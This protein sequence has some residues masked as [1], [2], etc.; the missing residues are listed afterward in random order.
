MSAGALVTLVSFGYEQLL[1][2]SHVNNI[3]KSYISLNTI[4]SDNDYKVTIPRNG[5]S[6][7]LKGLI[8]NRETTDT[9][10]NIEYIEII[11]GTTSIIN[12]PYTLFK[13]IFP[14]EETE[15]T[16]YFKCDFSMFLPEEIYL[17]RL[18]FHQV[19]VKIH[20][21]NHTNIKNIVLP[22]E[23]IF[24]D[25]PNRHELAIAEYKQNCIQTIQTITYNLTTSQP[26]Q[27]APIVTS[28]QTNI[29]V[30]S[31]SLLSKGLFIECP[32]N[33]IKSI[34]IILQSK[35][36]NDDMN[37]YQYCNYDKD[38]INIVTK[39]I[40]PDLLYLP[41]NIEKDYAANNFA[42]Y[43][44]GINMCSFNN[45][46]IHIN[47]YKRPEKLRIHSLTFNIFKTVSGMGTLVFEPFDKTMKDIV[48]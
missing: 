10:V 44:G 26:G 6:A 24:Y 32:V 46:F 31:F 39:T 11:I 7:K 47:T 40:T 16:T 41:F 20:V 36:D 15:T 27:P 30:D 4:K 2:N 3:S 1:S 18:A 14:P 13:G 43:Q 17:V 29:N 22:I 34:K 8:I 25:N 48:I 37:E 19:N 33:N 35:S 42:S 23:Y 5:D 12:I 45:I 28:E 21:S 38:M 9:H